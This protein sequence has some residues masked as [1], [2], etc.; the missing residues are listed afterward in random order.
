M[1]RKQRQRLAEDTIAVLER[2]QYQVDGATVSLR[3]AI[4]R[5]IE[6]T[7][8]YPPER[9][10]ANPPAGDAATRVRVE[11]IG[12]L[13]A[14]RR[15]L[16]EGHARVCVLNFAS[17]YLA[18]GGWLRGSQAQEEAL[19][20]VSALYPSL[21]AAPRY[22]AYHKQ[23]QDPMHSDYAIYSPAVPVFR[24]ARGELLSAPWPC[25]FVTCPA[26]QAKKVRAAGGSE[27][28]IESAMAR[29][30]ARVLAIM[31]LHGHDAI[32]LGAWGCGV[33]G[34]A[35]ET[36]AELFASQLRGEF[37]GV[38]SAVD[39][40]VLDFSD[41]LATLRPFQRALTP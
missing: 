21:L 25:S 15:L 16:D 10:V 4:D 23:R 39:F 7:V 27:G 29:R 34:N 1:N 33:F 5:A 30:V 18:G 2:G 24:E 11:N 26:V 6:G 14:A 20:R 22:Y 36:I 38:F 12:A 40:A 8:E 19:V 13:A 9:E 3:D 32:V 17:A 35:P 37:T 31:A 41:S 28:A